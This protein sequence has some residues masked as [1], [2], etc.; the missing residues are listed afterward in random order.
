MIQKKLHNWWYNKHPNKL[1]HQWVDGNHITWRVKMA[2]I[3]SEDQR[4]AT[5]WGF[6]F[7][8]IHKVLEQSKSFSNMRGASTI[9]QQTAKNLFLWPAHSIIRKGM[10]AYFT[11]LMELLWPK[12]RIL[13]MY[14]NVAQFGPNVFGV[15]AASRLYFHTTAANLTKA[16]SALMVTA[17]PAP[18]D[19]SLAHPSSYMLQR[20]SWVLKYMNKLG[21]RAYLR[22]FE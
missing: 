7:H 16:Q 17:L 1:H 2:A 19:Y 12:K 8:Q 18:D 22:Q 4:F 11:I 9:T 3:T 5:D 21:N 10:E 13:E 20:R 6:N 15:Q 14:L